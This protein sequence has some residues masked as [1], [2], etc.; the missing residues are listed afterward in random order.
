LG[1]SPVEFLDDAAADPRDSRG[2]PAQEDH[3]ASIRRAAVDGQRR[4]ASLAACL[5]A[6]SEGT[7]LRDL[8]ERLA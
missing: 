3:A 2:D 4:S 6:V 5:P 8:A 1:Q 7:R